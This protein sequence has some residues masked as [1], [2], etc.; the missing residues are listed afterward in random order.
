[1]GGQSGVYSSSVPVQLPKAWMRGAWL[2]LL[3]EQLEDQLR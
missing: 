3:S 2:A 1:M